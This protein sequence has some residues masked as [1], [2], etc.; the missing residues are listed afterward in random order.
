[1][2]AA[3]CPRVAPAPTTGMFP[4]YFF[5]TLMRLKIGARFSMSVLCLGVLG[6]RRRRSVHEAAD[7]GRGLIPLDPIYPYTKAQ[8]TQTHREG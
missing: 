5:H 7:P 2:M 8:N 3:A 6:G 1:M 4:L